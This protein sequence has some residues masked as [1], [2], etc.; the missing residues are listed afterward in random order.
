VPQGD[1]YSLS[2]RQT[3]ATVMASLEDVLADQTLGSRQLSGSGGWSDLQFAHYCA[4]VLGERGYAAVVVEGE[5]AAPNSHWVL[6]LVDLGSKKAVIPVAS[7]PGVG[8]RQYRLGNVPRVGERTDVRF[9]SQYTTYARVLDS[10]SNNRPV[11]QIRRP[12]GDLLVGDRLLFLAVGSS[13][14]DGRIVLYRWRVDGGKPT[15]GAE[16]AFYTRL[17]TAG[18]H[19]VEL[20]V[21]DEYGASGAATVSITVVQVS[22]DGEPEAG[23]GCGG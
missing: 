14:V 6:V 7:S 4:G 10:V 17:E 5:A 22:E 23:C 8:E 13:D 9:S 16:T 20:T 11:A 21:V 18:V 1:A 2:E 15:A 19:T 12:I 3:I